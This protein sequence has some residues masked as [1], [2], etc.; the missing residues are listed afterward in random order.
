MEI[1]GLTRRRAV[2][3]GSKVIVNNHACS[4]SYNIYVVPNLFISKNDFTKLGTEVIASI[5]FF[6]IYTL[7]HHKIP[8]PIGLVAEE[9]L[10][11]IEFWN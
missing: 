1:W 6:W 3:E 10:V 8:V 4:L 2:K 11:H 7:S 5:Y 9:I